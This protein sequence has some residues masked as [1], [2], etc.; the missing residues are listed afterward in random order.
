[1]PYIFIVFRHD[2]QF[3]DAVFVHPALRQMLAVIGSFQLHGVV[4]HNTIRRYMPLLFGHQQ[5]RCFRAI[6]IVQ[7]FRITGTMN[8]QVMPL[9]DL[10]QIIEI[11]NDRHLSGTEGEINHFTRRGYV[12]ACRCRVELQQLIS[13]SNSS[14]LTIR[15]IIRRRAGQSAERRSATQQSCSSTEP[16]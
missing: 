14:T 9:A 7:F 1:M 4:I 16:I 15:P 12:E 11:R 2:L 10:I 3:H 13:Q 6:Q 5:P 8:G